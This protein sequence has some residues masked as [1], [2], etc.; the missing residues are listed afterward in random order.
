MTLIQTMQG[1]NAP[2]LQQ[3]N[4]NNKRI[5]QINNSLVKPKPHAQA[6]TNTQTIQ[7]QNYE[8]ATIL[9]CPVHKS[10]NVAK[11]LQESRDQLIHEQYIYLCM[12]QLNIMF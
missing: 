7:V 10:S 5:I 2:P 4:H 3:V 12:A 1:N 8:I 11:P 6:S 9:A